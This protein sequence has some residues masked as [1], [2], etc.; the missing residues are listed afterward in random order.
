MGDAGFKPGTSAQEIW[1]ATNEP[2]HLGIQNSLLSMEF[3]TVAQLVV[4]WPI[5]VK[6]AG[7]IPTNY[8]IFSSLFQ[9]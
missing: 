7:L 9:V 2:P 6:V 4:S 5:D 3:I 1:H 8:L